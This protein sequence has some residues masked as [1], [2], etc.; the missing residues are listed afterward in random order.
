[1]AIRG[2][3]FEE[4][5]EVIVADVGLPGR[6]SLALGEAG[7]A[8]AWLRHGGLPS[9]LSLRA[10]TG[11]DELLALAVHE[12]DVHLVG[13]E[14]NGL[15]RARS[16]GRQRPLPAANPFRLFPRGSNPQLNSVVEVKYFMAVVLHG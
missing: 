6:N 13:M 7:P 4:I 9:P 5:L 14:V 8:I 12:A 3:E 15:P 1:M 2:D 10:K 16:V 11:V